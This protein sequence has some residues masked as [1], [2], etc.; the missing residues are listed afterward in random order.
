MDTPLIALACALVALAAWAISGL[1][2]RT[3]THFNIVD[4]PNHRSSHSRPCPRGGGL[5]LIPVILVTWLICTAWLGA[6][7][8]L[9]T[10]VFGAALLALVSWIDDLRSLRARIRLAVQI[11]AVLIGLAA[12]GNLPG[13]TTA[14]PFFQ[15]LLPAWLDGAL[16]ALLWLWFINLFNF[17]DGIDGITG[18]QSIALG[19]GLTASAGLAGLDLSM[20]LLPLLIAAACAGFLPWNWQPARIFLGDVGSVPLGYLFG[21]LLLLT[22]REG[23]WAVALILPLYYLADA[24]LTLLQRL[25]RRENPARAHREHFYQRAA[26]PSGAA[27]G[28]GKNHAGIVLRIGLCNLV[29]IALALVTVW[30]PQAWIS[31]MALL[32]AS[33]AVA[34][35]LTALT[36]SHQ[37]A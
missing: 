29:L 10:A 20:I 12:M 9:F 30:W 21:W 11:V 19:V 24:S 33:A 23:L 14:A 5:A 36:K 22:A 26:A 37:Q 18:A 31:A 3:L 16:A 25:K 4:R 17:M 32:L 7:P 28:L 34:A 27:T 6:L 1:V 13:A 15:G 2:L 35:L 8:G